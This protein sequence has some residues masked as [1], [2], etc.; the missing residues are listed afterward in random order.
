MINQRKKEL[1]IY[2][3]RRIARA[4][5]LKELRTAKRRPASL[6]NSYGT[7]LRPSR[8]TDLFSYLTQILQG[9]PQ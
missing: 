8:P 4:K 3:K 9:R 6:R 5:Y 2:R 1:R 7:Q